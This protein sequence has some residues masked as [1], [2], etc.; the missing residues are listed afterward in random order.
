VLIVGAAVAAALA[1]VT[2]TQLGETSTSTSRSLDLPGVASLTAGLAMVAYGFV[3]A[4]AHGWGSAGSIAGYVVG[5][6]A[7]AGFAVDQQL[8]AD[9]V[10]PRELFRQRQ[11]VSAYVGMAVLGATVLS[12]YF[13]VVQFLREVRGYSALEAGLSLL[14]VTIV[15]VLVAGPAARLVAR[16]G[17]QPVTMAGLLALGFGLLYLSSLSATSS[18]RGHVLGGVLLVGLGVGGL[19]AALPGTAAGVDQPAAD[20]QVVPGLL[21]LAQ[22]VGAA[23]GLSA[24]VAVFGAHATDHVAVGFIGQAETDAYASHL[25]TAIGHPWLVRGFDAA[26][27]VGAVSALAALVVTVLVAAM[28]VGHAHDRSQEGHSG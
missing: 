11:A 21:N 6:L 27:K 22:V 15:V 7:L 16:L 13:F 12:T 23:I 17:S 8:A 18:Y 3:H 24:L 20:R 28:P 10:L 2:R 19:F 9:P 1:G 25:F 14:P 4:A 5:G 26:F